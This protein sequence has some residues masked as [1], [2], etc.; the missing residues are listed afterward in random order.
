MRKI[1]TV[2]FIFAMVSMT[3]VSF[4]YSSGGPGGNA[5]DPVGSN[6][7]NCTSCHNSYSLQTSGPTWK[8]IELSGN[9]SNGGYKNDSTYTLELEHK[10]SGIT[11]WGFQITALDTS[12]DPIGTISVN[13]AGSGTTRRVSATKG[14][15]TRYYITHSSSGTSGSGGRSWTFDWKADSA[16]QGDVIFYAVVNAANGSGTSGDTIYAREFTIKPDLAGLPKANIAVNNSKPCMFDTVEFTGSGNLADSFFWTFLN[17]NITTSTEQ[18]PK[19]VFNSRGKQKVTLVTKNSKGSSQ[20]ASTTIDVQPLP[21]AFIMGGTSFNL[22]PGDSVKLTAQFNVGNTYVWSNGFTGSNIQWVKKP[23][24]YSVT[25]SSNGCS[26]TSQEVTVSEYAKKDPKLIPSQPS[27][28]INGN[29]DLTIRVDQADSFFWSN[30][31]TL[32]NESTDSTYFTPVG[33]GTF[34]GRIKDANGCF[35]NTDTLRLQLVQPLPAPQVNCGKTTTSS[36][37]VDW[38]TVNGATGYEVKLNTGSWIQVGSNTS[39][40]FTGLPP[41]TDQNISVRALSSGPC[42]FGE[43]GSIICKTLPCNDL[44]VTPISPSVVCENEPFNIILSGLKGQSYSV[45]AN[46]NNPTT[47]TLFVY[48]T[49]FA[50]T[51]RYSIIDSSKLNCP[52]E[53]IVIPI[54]VEQK[55]GMNLTLNGG[56]GPICE[57]EEVEL[58]ATEG[59]NTYELIINEVSTETGVNSTFNLGLIAPNTEIE[60]IG[61]QDACIES[62]KVT[63][64]VIDAPEAEFELSHLGGLLFDAKVINPVDS[65]QYEWFVN[66]VRTSS[67]DVAELDLSALSGE[68]EV[69]LKAD[70]DNGCFEE[71]T[72]TVITSDV[73]AVQSWAESQLVIYPNPGKDVVY[74]EAPF[75]LETYTIRDLN[76]RLIQ[77]GQIDENGITITSLDNGTYLLEVSGDY[78]LNKSLVIRH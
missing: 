55:L 74:L 70:F 4:T 19:V 64:S 32:L 8:N 10:V 72:D 58:K 25:V 33:N 2:L 43:E 48:Q 56:S 51:F 13:S 57:N 16:Y 52:A 63:P 22:C 27:S 18:N 11:K 60:V 15:K 5:N 26:R 41:E 65:A 7:Q 45:S 6:R 37:E 77:S 75:R 20:P 21:T 47:D 9:W 73:A 53:E 1:V 68:V 66:G 14:G 40:E 17:A 3:V 54:A 31:T 46:G 34:I 62:A 30:Q 23:G 69:T 59:F 49:E 36:V 24:K 44:D 76:G 78:K 35:F 67:G 28:C 29:T 42:Q 12:Q 38:N 39:Y 71:K 61:S 50:D